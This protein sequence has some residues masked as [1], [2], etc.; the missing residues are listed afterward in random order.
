MEILLNGKTRT[1]ICGPWFILTANR[2]VPA[3]ELRQRLVTQDFRSGHL[4]FHSN[5]PS[6]SNCKTRQAPRHTSLPEWTGQQSPNFVVAAKLVF[7]NAF[8]VHELKA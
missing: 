2:H 1:K 8:N 5:K 4:K 3:S 7:P 6:S